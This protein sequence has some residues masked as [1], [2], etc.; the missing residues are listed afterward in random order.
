MHLD[1]DLCLEVIIA[2]GPASTLK[3]LADRLIGAKGV[4][5]GDVSGLS[6]VPHRKGHGH[7]HA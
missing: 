2:R 3:R 1:A 7:K 4:I 6:V 5:S